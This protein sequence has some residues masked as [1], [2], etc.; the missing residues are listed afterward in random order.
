MNH[1]D[2]F[3]IHQFRGVHNLRLAGLGQINLLVGDNN[4]GKT[5]VLEA[6]SLYADP[7]NWRR[8]SSIASMRET[9]TLSSP[10]MTE[11]LIWLFPGG[12]E[13]IDDG[14]SPNTKIILSSSGSFPVNGVS[15]DYE[16]FSEIVQSEFAQL[17]L[18]RIAEGES[19]SLEEREREMEAI[20]I[21]VTARIPNEVFEETFAFPVNKRF[22]SVRS[23]R[24]STF[25]P[26]Q[27][28]HPA[29]H[30]LATTTSQLWS[31]VINAETKIEAIKLLR[32][33][34]RD[35]EDVDII[36]S[37]GDRPTISVKH[38]KL[39]RAPL[40]TF[41]DGL[42]RI[43]TLATA[44]PGARKGL[45]L[46]D[47]LEMAIHTGALRQTIDWLVNASIQNNIQLFCTTHSLE[48]VDTVLDVAQKGVVI[49]PNDAPA[50]SFAQ[51]TKEGANLVIYRL[52]KDEDNVT[53]TRFDKESATRLREELGLEIR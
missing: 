34:D 26:S 33:F 2:E 32:S 10:S 49:A 21:H 29:S 18:L 30:R 16:N 45:L 14:A 20:K 12:N 39:K 47:E 23:S 27:L 8:W 43:F 48:T 1:L 40:S 37:H 42:R 22:I 31:D 19:G 11:K 46:V 44:I 52:R 7:L 25:L 13:P 28:I 24:A 53:I 15:A 3:T 51:G 38:R 41:G 6:L 4:S 9:G 17:S 50:S 35:I 36:V 5:S